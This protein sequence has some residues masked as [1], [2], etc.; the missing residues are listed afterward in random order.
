MM[1]SDPSCKTIVLI[2]SI[3]D[4]KTYETNKNFLKTISPR[5]AVMWLS[6]GSDVSFKQ[7]VSWK[8]C[9]AEI[10]SLLT[11]KR[12]TAPHRYGFLLTAALEKEIHQGHLEKSLRVFFFQSWVQKG[13]RDGG[14]VIAD[15]VPL[16]LRKKYQM[17]LSLPF[18]PSQSLTS[19]KPQ[20]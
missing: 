1:S 3:D 20:Q 12:M 5:Y 8:I 4:G 10:I 6:K 15:T 13:E 18:K 7:R 16:P 17:K 19:S 14:H 11:H 9:N 2:Y